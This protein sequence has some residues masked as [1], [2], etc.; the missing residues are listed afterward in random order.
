MTVGVRGT[1]VGVATLG[2]A[3]AVVVG[4]VGDV[5]ALSV[6]PWR[7]TQTHFPSLLLRQFQLAADALSVQPAPNNTMEDNK[8]GANLP[9]CLALCAVSCRNRGH[10]EYLCRI[11]N[12][13]TVRLRRLPFSNAPFCGEIS[14]IQ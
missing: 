3:G 9:E 12:L 11:G 13:S 6:S 14:E 5:V 2:V 8:Y 4:K 7:D 1:A 10:R